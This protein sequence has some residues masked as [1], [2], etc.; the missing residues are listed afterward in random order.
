MGTTQAE[1]RGLSQA[2]QLLLDYV[3]RYEVRKGIRLSVKNLDRS[4]SGAYPLF[5]YLFPS[6]GVRSAAIEELERA[7]WLR[8]KFPNSGPDWRA[9]LRRSVFEFIKFEALEIVDRIPLL[10]IGEIAE[11]AADDEN[12]QPLNDCLNFLGRTDLRAAAPLAKQYSKALLEI[13][14]DREKHRLVELVAH[15]AGMTR[16]EGS[17]PA[18]WCRLPCGFYESSDFAPNTL[19]RTT[20]ALVNCHGDFDDQFQAA[21]GLAG[22]QGNLILVLIGE[23]DGA[24]PR[25]AHICRTKH[26]VLLCESDLKDLALSADRRQSMRRIVFPQVRPSTLSPFRYMGPVTGDSFFGRRTE[27]QRVLNTPNGNFA[28]LGAR[29][30]GKTSLLMTIR[31]RVNRGP[32]RG[33]TIAVFT[34][35]T[36]NRQLRHFQRNLMQAIL[37]E[38]EQ[39]GVEIGWIDPGEEFFEDLAA[40]LRQSG[41]RYLFLFDEVDNLL[42]DPRISQI[43][44]FVRTISNTGCG[45]FVLS[46]YRSLRERTEDRD[47]FFFNLFEPII[48]SPLGVAEAYDLVRTQM[49]RIYIGF[50]DYEVVEAILDRGSTFASYLQRMCHLLLS[51]LDEPGRDRTIRLDDVAAVYQGEEFTRAI[52]SAV[53]VSRDRALDVL[54]RLILYWAAARP[55]PQFTEKELLEGLGRYVYAPRLTEVRRSLQYL[56]VTYL[57]AE[58]AGRYRFYMPHLREKLREEADL[59]FVIH[60]FAREYHDVQ[61]S[62]S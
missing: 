18:E 42:Q 19:F 32:E 2:A 52:T 28:I 21:M 3:V 6:R 35:A 15:S 34:D 53:T 58:S 5:R 39:R 55:N 13:G 45:R 59:E 44:E 36:Q 49:A 9:R 62:P 37:K 20:M 43:E 4:L 16:V 60:S 48:L 29:T 56:T 14:G 31:D 25:M 23:K 8:E 10:D 12:V 17:P 61:R 46:G 11:S 30:I 54:E 22:T 40:A 27:M 47:S 24:G 1:L 33:G 50:E 26:A 41:Q 38:A 57:L 51:R 7:G